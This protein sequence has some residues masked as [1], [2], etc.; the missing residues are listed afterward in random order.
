MK[1]K[2]KQ[3]ELLNIKKPTEWWVLIYKI[4]KNYF[5]LGIAVLP[6]PKVAPFA[7]LKV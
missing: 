1:Y 6:E 2:N 7:F 3:L 5:F 4:I